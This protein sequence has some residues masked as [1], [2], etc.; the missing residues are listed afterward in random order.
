MVY[1]AQRLLHGAFVLLGVTAVV[2]GLTF[3]TGDPASVLVPLNTSQAEMDRYRHELGLDRPAPI[4]YLDFLSRAVRG[5]FGDSFRHH[6]PAMPLVLERLPATLRLSAV[7][8]AFALII[9]I[10]LGTLAA[11][12]H[13]G[14][15]DALSR[16]AALLGQSIPSFWLAIVL[17][18]AFSV[19]L[20][21][22]PSSGADGW[23]SLLLPGLTVGAAS[24]STLARLLRSSLLEVLTHDYIR[25][26]FAKGLSRRSMLLHHALQNAALPFLSFMAL[27]VVFVLSNAVVVE[28]IF[29]YPGMGRLAVEAIATRDV[30]VIQ[31]FVTVAAT[32][33]V[34]INIGVDLLYTRLDPR[35]RLGR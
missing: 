1:L 10:P 15:L 9:S 11:L 7:A 12:H 13:N 32:W 2:F 26:A 35:I 20:R 31:A 25:T 21:W 22:L 14:R 34:V 33:V 6:S 18:L 5:D 27:Q 23:Q 3:L 17:I 29:A 16:L 28:S 24:A 19:Y 30:P 4:Q 8:L